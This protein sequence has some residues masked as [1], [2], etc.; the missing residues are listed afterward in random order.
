[1]ASPARRVVITGMGVVS[2]LGCDLEVFWKRNVSGQSGIR[3]VQQFDASAFPSQIAGE[4][5]EFDINAFLTPKEQ[6]RMDPFAHFAMG[7]AKLAMKD[8]GLDMSREEPC[9]A[10]VIAGSGIGGLQTMEVQHRTLLERG[11][12]RCSPFMIPQMISNMISGNIAIE[13]GMKGPNYGV[14]SACATAAHA[15]GDAL[16]AIQR[17]EADIMVSGGSDASICA[18]GFAGFCALRALST[19]NDEPQRASRPF[20]RDRD[21]FVM[22]EGAA[23]LVLEELEHARRR[24]ARI[25]AELAGFGA[26]CDAFHE[27]AP[28]EDGEGAARAMGM[29]MKDAGLT[30]ADVDYVNAH[31]TSTELN[32]KCETRAIKTA[33]GPD[34]ARRIMVS[35]T[36][37]MTGHLLGAAGGIEAVVCALAI[38]RGVVPPTINYENPDPECDLDYVPNTAR[39]TRVRA[40]VSNSLGFGG[41]NATLLIKAV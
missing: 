9:R 7:A 14:V 10:G 37:S 40:A 36:K 35:S 21:G 27:T 28:S 15:L 30:P 18:L 33:F 3:R 1:M 32:D 34:H 41:H 38:Q 17:D 26:T 24:G 29:A 39:E 23:I 16:R 2:P 12:K 5:V 13:Y 31:G 20:D 22:G 19:R 25:Y 4:V 6:R 11:P 8:S